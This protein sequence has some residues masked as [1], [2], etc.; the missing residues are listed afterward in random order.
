MEPY[1]DR[2][3]GYQSFV[4]WFETNKDYLLGENETGGSMKDKLIITVTFDKRENGMFAHYNVNAKRLHKPV[5]M[6]LTHQ[7]DIDY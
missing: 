2:A 5:I 7:M 3:D 4:S 1:R 6:V